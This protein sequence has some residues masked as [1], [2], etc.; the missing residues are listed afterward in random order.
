MHLSHGKEA[1]GI[2]MT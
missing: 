2:D 1:D